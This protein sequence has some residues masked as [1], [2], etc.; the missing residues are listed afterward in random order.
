S[1]ALPLYKRNFEFYQYVLQERTESSD[2]PRLIS[3]GSQLATT[4]VEL[5]SLEKAHAIMDSLQNY[6]STH[7]V[8]YSAESEIEIKKAQEKLYFKENKTKEA[9]TTTKEILALS[10]SI[11]KA[12]SHADIKWRN[13]L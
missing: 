12:Y 2:Y 1:E 9:Y 11:H 3:A 6:L 4:Y 5:D 8:Q 10:D 7:L 13:Q